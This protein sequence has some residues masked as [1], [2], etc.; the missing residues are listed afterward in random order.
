M[1]DFDSQ[2]TLAQIVTD[3]PG[4]ARVFERWGIDYCCHGQRPLDAACA[5]LNVDTASV[6]ADLTGLGEPQR[7]DWASLSPADLTEHIVCTHHDYLKEELPRLIALATKVNSVHGE[8]HPEL[9]EVLTLIQMTEADLTPHM[10]REELVVFPAI[11]KMSEDPTFKPMFG[12]FTNPI[13]TL[14]MEHDNQGRLLDR[15]IEVTGN[16]VPPG[17]GCASYAALYD[18]LRNLDQD[19]RLHVHKENNVLFPAVQAMEAQLVTS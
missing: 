12:N 9:A 11:R 13:S 15:L 19:T 4:S 3:L 16:F 7:A 10:Q 5:E 1:T 2:Q 14:M 8:R 18:G 6:V 17:D